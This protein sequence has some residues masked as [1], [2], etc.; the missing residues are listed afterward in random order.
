[1]KLPSLLTLACLALQASSAAL[2]RRVNGLSIT[3]HP[4]PVKRAKVQEVVCDP[5]TKIGTV[6][7]AAV[8]SS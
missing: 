6:L 1:M 4:D 3:E 7:W 5:N 8:C 2:T